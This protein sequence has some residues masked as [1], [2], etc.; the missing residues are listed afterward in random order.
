MTLVMV[1][2]PHTRD[3]E[4]SVV[5]GL[6]AFSRPPE[7]VLF[8]RCPDRPIADARNW[9]ALTALREKASHLL[10]WDSDQRPPRGGLL[11]LLKRNKDVVGCLTFGRIWPHWPVSMASATTSKVGERKYAVDADETYEFLKRYERIFPT[12]DFTGAMLAEDE[13]EAFLPRSMVGMAF[14][15]I[16]CSV[17]EQMLPDWKEQSEKSVPEWFKSDDGVSKEDSYFCEMASKVGAEIWM[18]R[19][20]LVGHGYGDQ[21][22]N[23]IDFLAWVNYLRG[24]P[25]DEF[26]RLA[27]Y[28]M[29]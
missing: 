12:Q 10:Y 19:S 4:G 3:F 20:V 21:H 26:K 6:M 27:S 13:P 9:L 24:L 16:K 28:G 23:P 7:G 2:I 5:D 1:G 8:R 25:Q 17:F 18:D 29:T 14:T 11:R 15:L 22:I